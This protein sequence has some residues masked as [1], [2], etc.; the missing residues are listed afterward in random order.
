MKPKIGDVIYLDTEMIGNGEWNPYVSGC[1]FKVTNTY[2]D[3]V[4]MYVYGYF[5]NNK[6]KW[7]NG[8]EVVHIYRNSS[9]DYI[10]EYVQDF[11]V[12]L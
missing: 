6:Y 9:K 12:G 11:D 7:S 4:E 8:E 3:R 5:K 1:Y 2:G 10:K